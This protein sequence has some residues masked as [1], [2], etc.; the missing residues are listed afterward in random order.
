MTPE[1]LLGLGTGSDSP[2]CYTFSDSTLNLAVISLDP[3][4]SRFADRLVASG[5]LP[6][7]SDAIIHQPSSENADI[8]IIDFPLMPSLF[9]QLD[10]EMAE[11]A[12]ETGLISIP[13][14]TFGRVISMNEQQPTFLCEVNLFSGNGGGPVIE[15]V[16]IIGIINTIPKIE[17]P[18]IASVEILKGITLQSA[19]NFLNNHIICL[20]EFPQRFAIA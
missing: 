4:H 9:H 10:V 8:I 20:T 14:F 13:T 15:G 7:S 12:W 16:T 1:F 5:Y 11:K 6:I 2:L 3:L 17:K 19:Y 18:D